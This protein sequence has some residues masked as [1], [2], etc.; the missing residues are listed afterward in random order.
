[1]KWTRMATAALLVAAVPALAQNVPVRIS[2]PAPEQTV[3]GSVPITINAASVPPT[4]YMVVEINDK[5]I[6]AVATD[7]GRKNLTYYWDTKA[8]LP[9]TTDLPRDGQYT[10]RVK[11]FTPDFRFARSNELNVYLRNHISIPANKGIHLKYRLVPDEAISLV[12]KVSAK[13]A[14]SE[15]YSAE[16]PVSLEINDVV[17]GV[18]EARE[19]IDKTASETLTGNAQA[20]ALAGR[21]FQVNLHTDGQI[22]PG[23]KMK[24]A[25]AMPVSSL[26][27]FPT[28]P[29]RIGD[30]WSN[31]VTITPF[32]NGVANAQ[33]SANN[34]LVG[35]E[36]YGGSPAA[37]I[38]STIDGDATVSMQGV[39]SKAHFKGTR[40]TYFDYVKGRLLA[41][42]DTLTADFG[43]GAASN[44]GGNSSSAGEMNMVITTSAK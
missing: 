42:V 6:A 28:V 44:P 11:T 3:R 1:M 25:G 36:Y 17:S 12:E 4:G 33:V 26:L 15:V 14:G 23:T 2:K 20:F 32:Y 38:E 27:V 8:P 13:S 40:I 19:K 35:L 7:S 5:F 29:V 41:S 43:G 37:K 21:S 9:D 39:E 10:L 16:V 18:A 22:T 24:R 31:Q 30:T 34:K